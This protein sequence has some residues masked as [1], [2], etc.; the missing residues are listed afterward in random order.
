LK[1]LQADG[2]FYI[3]NAEQVIGRDDFDLE[4]APPPDLAVEIDITR[5]SLRK[6]SIY[7]AL[8]V[9]EVWRYYGTVCRFYRLSE[10]RY[11]EIQVSD[12]LSGL[13]PQIIADAVELS[14]TVGQDEAIKAFGNKVQ[15]LRQP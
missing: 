6:L 7:A 14:K 11:L 4:T 5:K 13:T 12:S 10:G 1:G 2:C 3:Q 9:P 15:D 8:R